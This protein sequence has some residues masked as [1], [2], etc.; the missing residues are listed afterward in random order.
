MSTDAV[1]IDGNATAA[2]AAED[3][4]RNCRRVML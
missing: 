1:A 2:A 3:E 4:D